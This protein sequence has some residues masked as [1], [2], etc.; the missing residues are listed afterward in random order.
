MRAGPEQE[1]SHRFQQR[2]SQRCQAI[3]HFR[4]RGWI[5]FTRQV[6]VAFEIAQR[7]GEAALGDRTDGAL[8]LHE[9]K[10]AISQGM[11]YQQSPEVAD[12]VNGNSDAAPL[13]IRKVGRGY[14]HHTRDDKR[15]ILRASSKLVFM[16]PQPTNYEYKN[17]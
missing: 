1:A 6:A 3:L 12:L 5:N 8:D 7:L 17:R 10:R 2:L 14:F 9:S 15:A 4:R 16:D 13:R 11:E